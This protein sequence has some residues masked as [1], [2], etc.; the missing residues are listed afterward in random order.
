VP[1]RDSQARRGVDSSLTW[2]PAN[3]SALN[4]SV[5]GAGMEATGPRGPRARRNLARGGDQPSSRAEPYPRGRPALEQ[6]G[7]SLEEATSPRA[8]RNPTRGGNWPSGEA[9]VCQCGAAPLERSG[10]LPEGGWADCLVG[11][12]DHLGRGPVGLPYAC[13]RFVCILFFGESK[14]VSLVV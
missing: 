8:G 13:F 10:V 5:G 2:A 7:T 12:W 11:H 14:W 6:G 1:G 4:A 9:E 3:V